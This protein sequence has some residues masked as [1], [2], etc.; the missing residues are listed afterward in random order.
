MSEM[1]EL[2]QALQAELKQD[3]PAELELD[4]LC[5]QET[6][7]AAWEVAADVKARRKA[8]L[9]SDSEQYDAYNSNDRVSGADDDTLGL[10]FFSEFWGEPEI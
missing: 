9:D 5:C 2:H 3:L 4:P 8:R 10:V 6:M 1:E 7:P